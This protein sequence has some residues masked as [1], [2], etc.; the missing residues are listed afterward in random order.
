MLLLELNSSFVDS[1]INKERR[2]IYDN[3]IQNGRRR[4]KS[5]NSPRMRLSWHTIFA[6]YN[7]QRWHLKPQS[8]SI[9][10]S[11]QQVE[12]AFQISTRIFYYLLSY[13]FLLLKFLK[14]FGF[15]TLEFSPVHLGFIEV[16]NPFWITHLTFLSLVNTK[17]TWEFCNSSRSALTN[18]FKVCY[19]GSPYLTETF[20]T[21]VIL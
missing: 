4:E 16:R 5:P 21:R 11:R 7:L 14:L 1:E 12:E 20:A 15:K 17:I 9:L 10:Y 8:G 2:R 6:S 13:H 19:F 3:R 18:S